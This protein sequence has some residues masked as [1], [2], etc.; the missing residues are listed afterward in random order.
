MPGTDFVGALHSEGWFGMR[1][2]A[3]ITAR[4]PLPF[5]NVTTGVDGNADDSQG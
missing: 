4:S 2:A 1:V 3:L 5:H